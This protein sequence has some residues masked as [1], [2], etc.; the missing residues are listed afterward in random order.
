M[1]TKDDKK[2]IAG[3]FAT[4]ADFKTL[5]TD[6]KTLA[7]SKELTQVKVDVKIL[8]NKLTGVEDSYSR[9][10]NKVDKVLNKLDKFTG[11]VADLQQEN[12]MGAVTL[13]RHDIQIHELATVTRTSISE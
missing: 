5:A 8:A 11:T 10:E 9:M 4:K 3:K 7:T 12:K 1:L 2:W 13:R 6:I